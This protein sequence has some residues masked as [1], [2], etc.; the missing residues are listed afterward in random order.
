M[1][2]ECPAC[3]SK[4]IS[5]DRKFFYRIIYYI[6]DSIKKFKQL[7][8]HQCLTCGYHIDENHKEI[9]AVEPRNTFIQFAYKK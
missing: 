3:Y 4:N 9:M 5:Y 1:I 2:H 7:C 6:E 8:G